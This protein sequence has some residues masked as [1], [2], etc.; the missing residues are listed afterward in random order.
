MTDYINLLTIFKSNK[1]IDEVSNIN[2]R[3]DI[4]FNKENR[5]LRFRFN[6]KG[7]C[8]SAYTIEQGDLGIE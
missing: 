1:N 8:Y 4:H 3:I 5:T 6:N 2:N 7:E